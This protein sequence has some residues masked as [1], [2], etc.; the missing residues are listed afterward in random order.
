MKA[1]LRSLSVELKTRIARMSYDQDMAYHEATDKYEDLG[2]WEATARSDAHETWRMLGALGRYSVNKLFMENKELS[3]LCAPFVFQ[4][5]LVERNL[6]LLTNYFL[7]DLYRFLIPSAFYHRSF[8]YTSFPNTLHFPKNS[9][10]PA[11]RSLS[12]PIL[13]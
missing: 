1:T 11:A 8:S 5:L 12:N 9:I 6:P 3:S 10:S 13:F 2:S 7:I 4:V